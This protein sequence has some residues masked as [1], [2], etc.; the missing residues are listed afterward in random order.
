MKL[1]IRFMFAM[2]Y[3][4]FEIKNDMNHSVI[5]YSKL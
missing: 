3:C 1:K 4:A 5:L 2:M